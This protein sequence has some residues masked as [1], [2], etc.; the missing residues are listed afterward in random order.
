MLELFRPT[1]QLKVA[2]TPDCNND[3]PICLNKTTRK[4]NGKENMLSTAKIKDLIDQASDLGM[5][6][7]YWTGGEPMIEYNRVLEL[8]EYSAKRG[9]LPTIVT[10]GG[11]IGASGNYKELNRVLLERAGL[12]KLNTLQIVGS[13]KAAGL[14]RVY[15]SVDSSHTTLKSVNS[16]VYNLVP[17]EAVSQAVNGFLDEG[18]GKRH[19][20]EAIGYQLRITATASG[21]LSE[22]T[23][24]IIK[25]VMKRVGTKSIKDLSSN[26]FVFENE[27]GVI[28]LRRLNVA[29]LG[30]AR[31]LNDDALENRSG[32]KL[33]Q[34]ECPHFIARENAYDD[35]KHH[36]DL[37]VDHN[38]V[39]Y[40]CGN[41]AH[42]VGS[43]LEE[44]L[45]A[46]IRGVNRPSSKGNYALNRRVYHSL[47]VL[48]RQKEIGNRAIGEAF[49]LICLEHSELVGSIK[50]QCGACS[51]L[52][53]DR[54]LQQAF[55]KVFD[56]YRT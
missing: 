46:I 25:D 16:S 41:H 32:E 15:F 45:S 6:G 4:G 23:N 8:S 53:H 33:Y 29:S 28:L 38:G 56:K 31:S 19:S 34:I 20:L 30:D 40:T 1:A 7:V 22:P 11:L 55:L 52:G 42:P 17:S 51:C 50:T 13:L 44:P 12:F 10:N 14:T 39:V 3:C 26:T 2:V 48:S 47:L 37:F 27:K 49:R 9:L 43:V 21:L 18:Y 5:V 36:G 24:E 54:R 35:G